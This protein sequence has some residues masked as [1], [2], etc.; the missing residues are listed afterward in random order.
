MHDLKSIAAFAISLLLVATAPLRAQQW[1]NISGEEAASHLIKKVE[2][3]YPSFAKAA[4]VQG[5]V[6]IHVGIGLTGRIGALME[7]NGPPSLNQAAQNAVL[8]YVYKPFEKD[9]RPVAADTTVTVVFKLEGNVP[10][11][12]PLPDISGSFKPFDT[13]N[14]CVDCLV[15]ISPELR[16]W[17][18]AEVKTELDR[19]QDGSESSPEFLSLDAEL[20]N[21]GIPLPTG[22]EVIEV[23]VQKQGTHLYL[24][25]IASSALCGAT[26]NC[27]TELIEQDASGVRKA[28]GS[29]GG[30]YSI[31]PHSGS[32]YP[33]VFIYS[34]MAAGLANVAGYSNVDGYWGQLYCGEITWNEDGR[35]KDTIRT[36]CRQ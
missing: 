13:G 35:E 33:D 36:S 3:V 6:S 20:Q 25:R 7:M 21:F 11:P 4:G 18:T 30:G 8:Q 15:N 10:P 12:P 19:L 29:F 26:G 34:H 5:S 17:I 16:K 1:I 14:K 27:P 2:P 24:F 31:H 9:G 32:P 28:A 23:P 22:I